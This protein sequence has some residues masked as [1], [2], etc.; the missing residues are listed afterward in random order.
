MVVAKEDI[1]EA[2]LYNA[3]VKGENGYLWNDKITLLL[4]FS[5]FY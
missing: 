1:M 4:K 3:Y 2:S 5:D